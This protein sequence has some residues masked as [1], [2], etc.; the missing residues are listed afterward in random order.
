[1]MLRTI[2]VAIASIFDVEAGFQKDKLDVGNWYE[3]RLV[4]TNH[5]ISAPTLADWLGRPPTR[6]DMLDLTTPVAEKILKAKYLET[7][8]YDD[9]P[10]GLDYALL[11]FAVNSGPAR[12][13]KA[14]QKTLRVKAD[15][16]MGGMTLRALK[17]WK[18]D[19]VIMELS[20]SRLRFLHRLPN[21]R[22]F[23]KGWT[24]RVKDVTNKALSLNAHPYVGLK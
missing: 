19:Y 16:I 4:G 15:G 11:D 7:I 3:G 9:L 14:L 22:R 2:E 17:R 10:A 21:W 18:I 5:G 1:M 8:R 24:I 20:A 23:G 13:V 6:R 12:A